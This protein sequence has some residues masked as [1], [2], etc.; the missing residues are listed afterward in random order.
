M[1]HS[2]AERHFNVGSVNPKNSWIISRGK[3]P[4]I[5]FCARFKIFNTDTVGVYSD[6][7]WERLCESFEELFKFFGFVSKEVL[8]E[9]FQETVI[10]VRGVFFGHKNEM[11]LEWIKM[12]VILK[13]SEVKISR[14]CHTLPE[15]C[16]DLP[17]MKN[18]NN[19]SSKNFFISGRLPRIF[20][21]IS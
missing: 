11:Y 7:F 2:V 17:I 10:D 18:S 1:F 14:N 19:F 16:E 15:S 3:G 9:I 5:L 4:I 12:T 13:L 8:S 20:E 6:G 21:K